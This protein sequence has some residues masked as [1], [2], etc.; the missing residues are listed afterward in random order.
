MRDDC[1]PV[2]AVLLLKLCDDVGE[3]VGDSVQGVSRRV[4]IE[5]RLEALC[6]DPLDERLELLR[7]AADSVNEQDRHFARIVS[8]EEVDAGTE[9]EQKVHEAAQSDPSRIAHVMAQIFSP[10]AARSG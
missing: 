6:I 4:E 10:S 5:P 1:E 3:R 9:L 8:V 2:E 7:L